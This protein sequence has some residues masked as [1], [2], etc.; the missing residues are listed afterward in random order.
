MAGQDDRFPGSAGLQLADGVA[1]LHPEEQV[2]E[3]MLGG[4]R[5][6]QLARNLALS[7]INKRATRLRAFLVHADAFPWH[8]TPRHADEWFG[9]L[10]GV[11]NCS[12]SSL[13]SYQDALR[14]FCSY[15]TDPAYDWLAACEQRFGTFPIQVVH[16]GNAAVHVQE[17]E[18]RPE[19][20]AFTIDELQ[21]FFDYA[22]EQVT[23]ARDRGRKG[24]LPAFRDAT[25]FKIAYSFGLRR[26]ET[27]MLDT[28]DIGRNPHGP[29]L[30][31]YGLVHVRFGKAKK[32]S[33]PKRRSVA[34]V[35]RWTAEILEEWVTEI[36][37]QLAVAGNPALWPSERGARIGLQRINSRFAAYRDALGLDPGLDFHG[38]RRSYV[39]H[40][41]EEGKDPLFVQFQCGHEH[42]STTSLYT[43]VSSDFRMRT[44]RRALDD[45]LTAALEPTRKT[46]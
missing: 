29:E 21:D 31:D 27:R 9:D 35:W 25:L 18:A 28:V 34:T 22:D 45:T 40:L 12:H 43:C 5:N 30:G 44:I 13:R 46:P 42:A 6:Q 32:G 26:N 37:P 19:K 16:E 24:W 20:R 1:L 39:T 15:I 10:R 8:W 14:S 17:A 11:R 38:L 7:T 41:I 4:W 3:A 33:P 2:F 23:K 36:R